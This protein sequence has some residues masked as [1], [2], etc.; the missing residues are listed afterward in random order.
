MLVLGIVTTATEAASDVVT[1]RVVLA[2]T[3]V[4]GTGEEEVAWLNTVDRLL[5]LNKVDSL[6]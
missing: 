5:G 2:T 3:N 6:V 4:G 1:T